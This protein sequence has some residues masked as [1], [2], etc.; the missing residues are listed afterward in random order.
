[1]LVQKFARQPGEVEALNG[2][3]AVA[4]LQDLTADGVKLIVAQDFGLE[5]NGNPDG[6]SGAGKLKAVPSV[7]Q[8]PQ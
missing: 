5:S 6:V 3:D 7:T 4:D 2:S 1:M 8:R